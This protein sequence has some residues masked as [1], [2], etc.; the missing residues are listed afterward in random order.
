MK[1]LCIFAHWD[2]DNIVDD[3]VLYY[4]KNLRDIASTIIFISDSFLPEEEKVKLNNI[5]DFV[6]SEKHGEYD[7]GSYKRGIH[8]ALEKNLEFDEILL[9][10]DSC[11]GPF[12]P[13]EA[14]FQK[15]ARK[16]CDFWG[17]TQ[18]SYGIKKE[19]GMRVA[20]WQPHIQSYFLLLKKQVF[21][22]NVFKSFIKNITQLDDKELIIQNYEVGLTE[23]LKNNGF[24]SS[25]YINH[26][27]HTENCLASKWKR[28]ILRYKFPFLKT[29][30][31]KKGLFITGEIKD[32][33]S[34][35]ENTTSYPTSLIKNH[36]SRLNIPENEKEKNIFSQMNP[37]R[38]IRFLILNNSPMELRKIVITLERNS[39]KILNKLFFNKLKKF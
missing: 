4:L 29:S 10:N 36:I 27:T 34:V 25:V 5:A 3:Y 16:K 8:F 33:E 15:M 20:A 39:Y 14:I 28:L 26:F 13:L 6:I 12:Y 31:I 1:R 2:R 32:W 11:Y 37:Y 35:L 21:E 17:L 19:N 38:K 22:S 24:Q 23:L 18:N 30:V 7:F 9:V